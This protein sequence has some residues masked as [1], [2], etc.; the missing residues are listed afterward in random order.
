[1]SEFLIIT[2][3]RTR[4]TWGATG[5]LLNKTWASLK[6][7]FMKLL[8]WMMC[9]LVIILYVTLAQRQEERQPICRLSGRFTHLYHSQLTPCCVWRLLITTGSFLGSSATFVGNQNCFCDA[10]VPSE[11]EEEILSWW[12]SY[13]SVLSVSSLVQINYHSLFRGE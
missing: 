12:C 9:R 3:S 1:M 6:T 2:S 10:S 5:L 8:S 13:M 4:A 11:C 7:R